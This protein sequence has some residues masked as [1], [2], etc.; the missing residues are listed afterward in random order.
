M[1]RIFFLRKYLGDG[2]NFKKLPSFDWRIWE[3]IAREKGDENANWSREKNIFK[4]EDSESKLLGNQTISKQ[5]IL[6]I[7]EETWIKAKYS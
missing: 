5:E 2:Q 4:G 6:L 3:I 1:G 7:K